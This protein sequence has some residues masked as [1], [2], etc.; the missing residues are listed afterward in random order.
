MRTGHVP[1][2]CVTHVYLFY[3]VLFTG[4]VPEYPRNYGSDGESEIQS[5]GSEEIVSSPVQSNTPAEQVVVRRRPKT[6]RTTDSGKADAGGAGNRRW[7]AQYISKRLSL[8][9]EFNVPESVLAKLSGPGWKRTS[10]F[11]IAVSYWVFPES[12]LDGPLTRKL[13]RTSLSELGFG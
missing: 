10:F 13:R 4:A 7:D 9:A 2:D 3:I 5:G 1:L 11:Q 8:P 12:P 6:I